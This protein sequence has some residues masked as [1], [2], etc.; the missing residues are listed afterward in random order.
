MATPTFPSPTRATWSE[1]PAE[2]VLPG[3]ARQIVHG[4]RQ[5]MVRYVYAPGSVFPTHAHPEEQVT[6]VV[7]GRIAF[8]IAGERHELGPGDVA[9]IPPNVP[10]GARVVGDQT[11][12][13]FN[14]LSPRRDT[15]PVIAA[16]GEA[17]A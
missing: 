6:V 4:E 2:E 7:S 17:S 9:V 13:T 11:V 14:A 12:E 10:H 8:E 15:S 1:I 5:T 3:I 16:A